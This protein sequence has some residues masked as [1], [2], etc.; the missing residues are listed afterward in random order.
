MS[1]RYSGSNFDARVLRASICV[2]GSQGC[3]PC[4]PTIHANDECCWGTAHAKRL[5]LRLRSSRL[6]S[7]NVHPK[8]HPA[9]PFRH[10]PVRRVMRDLRSYALENCR[11]YSC[12]Y[13]PIIRMVNEPGTAAP[14]G[15]RPPPGGGGGAGPRSWLIVKMW[16]VWLSNV[17]VQAPFIVARFC[18]TSKLAGLFSLTTVNVPLPCVPSPLPNCRE[19]HGRAVLRRATDSAIG[20]IRTSA[21]RNATP[22]SEITLESMRRIYGSRIEAEARRYAEAGRHHDRRWEGAGAVLHCAYSCGTRSDHPLGLRLE[23]AVR[24]CSGKLERCSTEDGAAVSGAR[25]GPGDRLPWLARD[26]VAQPTGEYDLAAQFCRC[27]SRAAATVWPGGVP[28]VPGGE[29]RCPRTGS[30][31]GVHGP[32]GGRAVSQRLASG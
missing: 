14:W 9:T 12:S 6:R 7:G 15:P 20:G 23:I 1:A 19:K 21:A 13:L 10:L 30:T 24:H 17:I 11:G 3:P 31:L 18:S 28:G 27:A 2:D 8:R 32:E 22:A 26:P 16:F 29:L 5:P 4:D 25:G